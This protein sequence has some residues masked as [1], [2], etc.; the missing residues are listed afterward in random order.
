MQ[1]SRSRRPAKRRS[2]LLRVLAYL[3]VIAGG[4]AIGW[5]AA[6]IADG[7]IAQWVARQQLEKTLSDADSSSTHP[8]LPLAKHSMV[9]PENGTPLAELSIPRIGLS[10]VVLQGSDEHTLRQ[11]VGHIESTPLPGEAGNVGIAGHRDSYFRPLRNVQVGDDIMLE[12]PAGSVHYRVSSYRVVNPSEISVIHPTSDPVLTLV[13]CFPF[14]FVGAAPDR[15]IVRATL[16][17][18]RRPARGQPASADA[19]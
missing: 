4:A 12:T 9:T 1:D 3:L 5:C 11:G 8:Y 6:M 15:F 10:V 2:G 13:T 18:D 7:Q 19:Q 16:V 17:D 14:Y